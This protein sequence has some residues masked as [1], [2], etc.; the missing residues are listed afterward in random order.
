MGW[1]IVCGT[2]RIGIVDPNT[3]NSLGGEV[4]GRPQKSPKATLIRSFLLSEKSHSKY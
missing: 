3:G 4:D 2:N 1:N